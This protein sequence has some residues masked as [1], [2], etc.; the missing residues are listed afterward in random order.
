M[1]L[2]EIPLLLVEGFF[3]K[4]EYNAHQAICPGKIVLKITHYELHC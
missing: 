4:Y 3:V 2:W 1:K